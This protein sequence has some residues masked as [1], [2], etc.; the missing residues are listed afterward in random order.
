MSLF[1]HY[2]CRRQR[3]GNPRHLFPELSQFFFS[4]LSSFNGRFLSQLVCYNDSNCALIHCQQG[5]VTVTV[6]VLVVLRQNRY[7]VQGD[8]LQT[9]AQ[10]SRGYTH[11][12]LSVICLALPGLKLNICDLVFF[13]RSFFTLLLL[14]VFIHLLNIYFQI[15]CRCFEVT[16]LKK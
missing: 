11:N 15:F 14:L 12:R 3:R 6:K 13:L 5:L 10:R 9:P 8:L 7:C 2:S 16:I 4:F 1:S